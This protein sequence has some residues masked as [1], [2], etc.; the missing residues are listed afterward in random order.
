MDLKTDKLDALRKAISEAP[1]QEIGVELQS[2]VDELRPNLNKR[3]QQNRR[4]RKATYDSLAVLFE[5]NGFSICGSTL[6]S[7][8][9]KSNAI[10]ARETIRKSRK[11]FL[12]RLQSGETYEELRKILIGRDI[13]VST[14]FIEKYLKQLESPNQKGFEP[15]PTNFPESSQPLDQSADQDDLTELEE[16]LDETESEIESDQDLESPEL[17]LIQEPSAPHP[18]TSK[19]MRKLLTV[20]R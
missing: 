4:N 20:N 19:P 11:D 2:L 13:V 15:E 18:E 17:K 5:K 3:L 1:D 14:R 16:D 10:A 12:R 7:Y 9:G 6:R 8:L